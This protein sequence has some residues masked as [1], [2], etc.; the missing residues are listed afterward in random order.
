[1]ASF[2]LEG[3]RVYPFSTPLR[4]PRE[5]L[6]SIRAAASLSSLSFLKLLLGTRQSSGTG[7]WWEFSREDAVAGHLRFRRSSVVVIVSLLFLLGVLVLFVPA[8]I[9]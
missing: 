7:A 8:V 4:V 9:G 1:M 2:L 6:E 5:I 3:R